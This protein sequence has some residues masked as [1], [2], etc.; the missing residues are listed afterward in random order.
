MLDERS[1][2][3]LLQHSTDQLHGLSCILLGSRFTSGIF[4]SFLFPSF[5]LSFR[6]ILSFLGLVALQKMLGSLYFCLLRDIWCLN[7]MYRQTSD[8]VICAA[9]LFPGIYKSVS[10]IFPYDFL[11]SVVLWLFI[12]LG[13]F[14]MWSA[15]VKMFC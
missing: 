13:F 1:Q 10:S 14:L 11:I 7:N 12:L 6:G 15:T 9:F 2:T 5:F 4:F 8:F 3:V